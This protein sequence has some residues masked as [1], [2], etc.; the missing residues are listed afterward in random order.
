[1]KKLTLIAA[2]AVV[3]L[4]ASAQKNVEPGI[5][6]V[7]AGG[8]ISDLIFI[9][10]DETTINKLTGVTIQN[11][12]PDDVNRNLWIWDNTLTAGDGSNPGVDFQFD[13]Y[14][15]LVVG[16]AGWSGAGYNI[17]AAANLSTATWNDNTHFHL[18]YMS[19]GTA[20]ASVAFIIADGGDWGSNPAKIAVGSAF[21]DGG[22]TY[23]TVGAAP[24]ADWQGIDVTF[25]EL[26]KYWPA[27]DYKAVEAWNG[28]ILS[29]LAGGVQGQTIALDAIYFYNYAGQGGSDPAGIS[30]IA[31]DSQFVVTGR[32]I[33]VAGGNGIELYNI[34]GQLVKASNGTTVGLNGLAKGVYVVRSGK[35]VQKVLVK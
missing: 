10:L 4:S 18:A 29:F 1:M 8:T 22:S 14:V 24:T 34:A 20:P 31:D 12:A 5:A 21:V 19:P 26:K 30:D 28:N 23:P 3:A 9:Q 15:S 32:T 16:T 7:Q 13:G 35:K 2:A 27:F 17:A 25:G 6:T 33:S 11:A